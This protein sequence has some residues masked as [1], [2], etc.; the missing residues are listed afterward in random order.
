VFFLSA[1]VI[2]FFAAWRL[3][4]SN[5]RIGRRFVSRKGAKKMGQPAL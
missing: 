5:N 4:V 2:V 3:C 1:G